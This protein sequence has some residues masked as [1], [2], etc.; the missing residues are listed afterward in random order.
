MTDYSERFEKLETNVVHAGAPRPHIGGAV[1]APIFQSANFLMADEGAYDEV[2]VVPRSGWLSNQ[3]G[4]IVMLS[5][6]RPV[7]EL[8]NLTAF[9][10]AG[11]YTNHER[12]AGDP[13]VLV[14]VMARYEL[15]P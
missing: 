3:V 5:T 11:A 8:G 4:G 15:T 14:G 13:T 6:D 2:R 9:V 1:V 7:P 12:R 10:R